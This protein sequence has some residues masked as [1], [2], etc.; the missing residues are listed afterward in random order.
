MQT[1]TGIQYV[2]IDIANQFGL[3]RLPWKERLWWVDDNRPDLPA[4]AKNAKHELGYMKALRAL[5]KGERGIE[6]NHIM[7]LDA[8][9]SGLQ[10]MA[11]MSGCHNSAKAVNLI[12]TGQR[13]CIYSSVA[14]HMSTRMNL[15]VTRDMVKRPVMTFFYGSEAVPQQIF[16]EGTDALAVFYKV[17]AT[18]LRGPYELMQLIQEFWD[19][20]AEKYVWAMP[21]GHVCHVPV[22]S[23]IDKPIEIDE[24]NHLRFTYRA[25]VMAPQV[26]GK[27]LAANIVHS[28]DAYICRRMVLKANEAG[29]YLSPIHDC[30]Y[31]HPNHMNK[32]RQWYVELMAEV[33]RMNLVENIL[34]QISGKRIVYTKTAGLPELILEAEY[35]LS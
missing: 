15:E 12:D 29:V 8:T 30:F 2:K 13:E 11:A 19:S 7:G 1:F 26:K 31:T 4:L 22:T 18:T 17:L 32:V 21:D 20:K 24:A 9:A 27:S 6:T 28:V 14:Q 23:T 5:D 10:I 16:G 25:E 34:S 33:A 3:D 35:A